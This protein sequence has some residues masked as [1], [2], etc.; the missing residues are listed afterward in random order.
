MP[1]CAKVYRRKTRL[2]FR[3]TRGRVKQKRRE[4][5]VDAFEPQSGNGFERPKRPEDEPRPRTGLHQPTLFP[6][7]EN[8]EPTK[9]A[10][11]RAQPL[12]LAPLK[13]EAHV[14]ALILET[15]RQ[16]RLERV[17]AARVT[18]RPFRSTLYSYRIE[19]DGTA[20]VQLH[21]AF[22]TAP[23]EA[24]AQVAQL[25]L[26]RT[27]KA[28][29]E[30]PRGAFDAFVRALPK[31]AFNLPGARRGTAK[32]IAGPGKH[33]SLDESFARVNET[34]FAGRMARPKL[35]W[36][37]ARAR[38]ILGTY[39]EEADTLIVSQVFDSPKIPLWVLDYLM[40]HELLHKHLGV[41]RRADGKRCMHGPEFKRLERKYARYKDAVAFLKKM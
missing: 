27:K 35:R 40:Y 12:K 19:P 30:L 23:D 21:T 9:N 16:R 17:R 8:D 20:R 24:L 28:R 38:R 3:K 32:A 31:G 26:C 33:R 25:I 29:R 18:F 41:G 34:Y 6:L 13:S 37:P 11:A 10:P 15:A 22:R 2:L 36:S 39:R 5:A 7:E 1:D 4:R 14:E